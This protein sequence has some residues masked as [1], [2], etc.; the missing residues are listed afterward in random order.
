MAIII[1]SFKQRSPEWYSARAGNPG[2]SSISKIITNAGA[3][4]KS[5]G[6][7]LC[8]MAGELITGRCEEGFQSQAML[9]GYEREDAARTL[10]ELI[11][12][13][14]V[15]QV[16]IVYKNKFKLFHCSPDGLVG[17]D[18]LIELKNPMLK[19][20]VRYLLNGELPSDYFGQ[21]QMSLYVTGRKL[22]YFMS[23]YEG[24]PPLIIEVHRDEKFLSLLAKALN[25]F[26]ADLFLTVRRLEA[27]K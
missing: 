24:M 4:S 17:K 15:R 26:A 14:E 21:C 27:L 5:R 3:I 18:A 16:G 10:F 2:A 19:T 13:V 6:D 1:D 25:D 8:Q 12:G 9:N 22:C 23:A 7:Y 11:F 20:H